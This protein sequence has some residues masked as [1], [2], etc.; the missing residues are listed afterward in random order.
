VHSPAGHALQ[1]HAVKPLKPEVEMRL[2]AGVEGYNMQQHKPQ[3]NREN[4]E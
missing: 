4:T 1:H 2:A 3:E